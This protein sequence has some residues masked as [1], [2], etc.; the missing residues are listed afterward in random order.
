M[1]AAPRPATHSRHIF[2]SHSSEDAAVAEKVRRALGSDGLTPKQIE[3]L[4]TS[5]ADVSFNQRVR[6]PS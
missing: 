1:P 4:S 6:P 3:P 5:H 2:I